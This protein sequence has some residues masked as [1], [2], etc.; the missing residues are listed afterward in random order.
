M[1]Q[2]ADSPAIVPRPASTVLLLRD[3]AAGPEVY[4]LRRHD[5]S[6][7]FGG[8]YVFPGGKLD[9]AD[10]EVECLCRIGADP[11]SLHQALREAELDAATAAGLFYAACR[12]TFEEA[13]VLLARG[14]DAG[15]GERAWAMLRE[16]VGFAEV[17]AA[18]DLELASDALVPWSRWITPRI[19]STMARNKRFD[20]RFFVAALPEGQEAGFDDHEAVAGEWLDPREAL[21]RYRDDRIVIG[22]PQIMSLV[23]LAQYGS[24]AEVLEAARGR[25]PVL[26]EPE[27]FELEGCRVVAYPGDERHPLR[28]RVMVGPTRLIQRGNRFEPLEGIDALLECVGC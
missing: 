1:P 22:P 15:L 11:V 9:R 6:N 20:T 23:Q 24:T 26:I 16:G 18:H 19:P 10:C 5:D 8:A 13:R 7:A 2:S 3:G 25:G 4:M 14:A 12:E 17:L 21:R 27:P 28:D